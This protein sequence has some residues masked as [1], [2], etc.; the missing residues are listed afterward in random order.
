MV[1]MQLTGEPAVLTVLLFY[2]VFVSL[3]RTPSELSCFI[4]QI[5]FLLILFMNKINPLFIFTKPSIDD[6]F[7]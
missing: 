5:I 2:A 7:F 1:H 3:C 4:L 6:R